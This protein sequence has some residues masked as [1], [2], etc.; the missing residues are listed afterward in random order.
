MALTNAVPGSQHCRLHGIQNSQRIRVHCCNTDIMK[1]QSHSYRPRRASAQV[2]AD[3]Q[4]VMQP[5]RT[6][7]SRM[8]RPSGRSMSRS[9]ASSTTRALSPAAAFSSSMRASRSAAAAAAFALRF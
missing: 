9:A 8:A 1:R 2:S 4:Q 5:V 7:M 3:P 6:G